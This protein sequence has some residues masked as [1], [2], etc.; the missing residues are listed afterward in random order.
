MYESMLKKILTILDGI[1]KDESDPG[2]WWETSTGAEFGAS[3]L[4]EIKALFEAPNENLPHWLQAQQ[5]YK[6]RCPG[7][8]PVTLT[9]VQ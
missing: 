9:K 3:K 6:K 8:D 7:I 5:E 4:A 2:G 1:D